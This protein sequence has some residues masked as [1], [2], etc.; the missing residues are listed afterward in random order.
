[1]KFGNLS[2]AILNALLTLVNEK[3]FKN[4]DEIVHAPLKALVSASNEVPPDNQGLEALYD[5]FILR[6]IVE[7]IK[8]KT[9]F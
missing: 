7:P 8:E 4:G 1:M 9:T 2:P 6:L 3:I 5:R